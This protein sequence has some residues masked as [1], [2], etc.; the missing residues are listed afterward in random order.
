M[1]KKIPVILFVWG[2]ILLG[3]LVGYNMKG[4]YEVSKMLSYMKERYGEEFIHVESYA[5][6]PGKPYITMLVERKANPS[7]VAL[8]RVRSYN[9]HKYYEDNFLAYRLKEELEEKVKIPAERAFGKCKLY[10]K[11]PLFVFPG[12]FR[13]DMSAEEFL[14]NPYAM[15]QFYI[16][17]K[18]MSSDKQ[19]WEKKLQSFINRNVSEGYQIRGTLSVPASSENYQLIQPDNF[20]ESDYFGYEAWGELVFSMD[21]EGKLRYM[22]WIN[23]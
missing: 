12:E 18:N 15:P 22:R 4:S 1:T 7:Q 11:I 10:Y 16:Y 6:Q 3:V 20:A 21:G 14:S 8:V 19:I 13:A 17:P 2:M 23:K 5:G 9:G